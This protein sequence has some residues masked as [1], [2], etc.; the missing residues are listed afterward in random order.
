MLHMLQRQILAKAPRNTRTTK[1]S[2]IHSFI[3]ARD[4]IAFLKSLS[5]VLLP[6]LTC[7]DK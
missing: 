5:M 4:Q 6:I 7:Q 3:K 1:N 2:E